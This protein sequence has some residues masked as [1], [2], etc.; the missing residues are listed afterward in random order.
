MNKDDI[1]LSFAKDEV[2]KDYKLGKILATSAIVS[3]VPLGPIRPK[4]TKLKLFI[5]VLIL[6]YL[7]FAL[8]SSRAEASPVASNLLCFTDQVSGVHLQ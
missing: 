2:R 1:E 4:R 7:G 3:D 5:L 6:G 8:F